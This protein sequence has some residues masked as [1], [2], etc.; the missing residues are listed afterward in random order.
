MN[1][2]LAA[3]VAL[4]LVLAGCSTINPGKQVSTAQAALAKQEKKVEKT[5]AAMEKNEE[6]KK[7]QVAALAAGVRMSLG[8]VTNA[9]IEVKTAQQLNERVISIVGAPNLDDLQKIEL[10]VN[11]LNSEIEKE[12]LKG[13]SLLAEKDKTIIAIQKGSSDLNSQYDQQIADLNEKMKVI[14]KASD[15]KEAVINQMSGFFGLNAVFWGLKKFIM[16]SL[17]GIIIFLIVFIVLRVLSTVNP[18]AAAIFAVFN[19]IGSAFI[20]LLKV[21][22]PKAFEMVN[23]VASQKLQDV[24]GILVKMVDS[25]QEFKEKAKDDPSKDIRLSNILEKFDKEFD[26]HEKDTVESILKEQKWKS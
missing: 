9:P 12:K 3:F 13:V 17:T 6:A 15:E 19:V 7:A 18:I 8:Q 26:K 1:K 14:A 25:I 10:I 20:S 5:V 22:T 11:F 24:R 23:L 16:T 4:L 21:L 2:Y